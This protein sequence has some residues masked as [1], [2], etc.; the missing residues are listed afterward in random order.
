MTKNNKPHLKHRFDPWHLAKSVRKDLVAASKKRECT[1]LVPWI[2]SIVNHLWWSAAT[3]N[4]DP[5]LCQE[6]WKSIVYH[7]AGIHEWPGFE[8]FSAC[9]HEVLA[10][11]QRRNK[12]WLPFGSPA[13]TA[14]KD[15]SWKPKLLRDILLLADFVQTGALEVFHGIMA[16]K[17]LP[18]CQHY[19][20]NGMKCRTQLAII[21][22]NWNAGREVATTEAGDP[23]FKCVYPKLQKKWVAKPMYEEK[24]YQF[25]DYLIRDTILLKQGAIN[26]PPL[27]RPVLPA[28]IAPTPRGNKED[29]IEQHMSRF[30]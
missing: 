18:K 27:Q 12:V 14:L 30:H 11:E 1:N 3:C 28:N 21:D 19:S 8:L 24:S 22:N 4:G 29:I 15:V 25:V 20:Y 7:V 13:H 17:Y 2:S 10:E 6:K 16:K 9:E 26:V 23:R 5:Y